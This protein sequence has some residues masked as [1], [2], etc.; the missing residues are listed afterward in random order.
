MYN[1]TNIIHYALYN[2]DLGRVRTAL[3][4]L[5]QMFFVV[6]AVKYSVNTF[7][8][9]FLLGKN[10]IHFG[11]VFNNSVTYARKT[12]MYPFKVFVL[13]RVC[14]FENDPNSGT[15]DIV[16]GKGYDRRK[17]RRQHALVCCIYV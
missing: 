3:R 14:A 10:K 7:A 11:V 2:T 8:P 15:D 13:L 9:F 1:A 4:D 16:I 5:L 6:T 12:F 17:R